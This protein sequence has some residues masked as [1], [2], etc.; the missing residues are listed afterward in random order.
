MS[1]GLKLIR[2]RTR[3]RSTMIHCSRFQRPCAVAR[4]LRLNFAEISPMKLEVRFHE[5]DQTTSS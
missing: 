4:V 3:G 1:L 2:Q 5:D